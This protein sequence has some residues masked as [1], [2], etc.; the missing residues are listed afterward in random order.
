MRFAVCAGTFCQNHCHFH[1]I[2]SVA[3]VREPPPL[4]G[5]DSANFCK[6]RV[7][8]GQR[9]GSLWPYSRFFSRLGPLLVA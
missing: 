3:S 6:W 9:D 1:L 2:N 4:F 8:S 5:E 7:L